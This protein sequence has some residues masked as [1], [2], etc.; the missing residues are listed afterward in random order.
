MKFIYGN[1]PYCVDREKEKILGSF[2]ESKIVDKLSEDEKFFLHS[3][4]F[5][6]QTT[7]VLIYVVDDPKNLKNIE[8]EWFEEESLVIIC[9]HH[10]K[11]CEMFGKKEEVEAQCLDKVTVAQLKELISNYTGMKPNIIDYFIKQMHYTEDENISLYSI[12]SELDKLKVFPEVDEKLIDKI[13]GGVGENMNL[14][15][16]GR[17]LR[18]GNE[19]AAYKIVEAC[20]R[21]QELAYIGAAQR[22]FRVGWKKNYFQPQVVGYGDVCEP[23][24]AVRAL[25][26][27]DKYSFKIIEGSMLA[28]VALKM[29]VCEIFSIKNREVSHHD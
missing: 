20:P 5:F 15:D 11:E 12:V 10:T 29:S 22:Y 14:F 25:I 16:L 2:D 1:E 26:I 3:M 23:N 24:L 6:N 13:V 7:K 9:Y 18:N 17:H 28:H 8:K 21:G 27:L 4:S 19:V